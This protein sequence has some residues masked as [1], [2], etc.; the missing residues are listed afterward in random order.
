[1]SNVK[2]IEYLT[3]LSK[4]VTDIWTCL[5]KHVGNG[6]PQMIVT[7]LSNLVQSAIE[8]QSL[9]KCNVLQHSLNGHNGFQVLNRKS[10]CLKRIVCS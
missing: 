2:L 4:I 5:N 1:M 10:L 9:F 3:D 6:S 7:S 8:K